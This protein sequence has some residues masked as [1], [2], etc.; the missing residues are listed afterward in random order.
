MILGIPHLEKIQ[1]P[2]KKQTKSL[3]KK[4]KSMTYVGIDLHKEFSR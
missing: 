4:T 1:F 2:R 3:G